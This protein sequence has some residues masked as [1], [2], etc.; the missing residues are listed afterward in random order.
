VRRT[1]PPSPPEL[2]PRKKGVLVVVVAVAAGQRARTLHRSTLRPTHLDFVVGFAN[3]GRILNP[4]AFRNKVAK[5]RLC[6]K[7][8]ALS[9]SFR[10]K[11]ETQIARAGSVATSRPKNE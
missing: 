6:S 4:K 1:P 7:E 5:K 9:C 2:R 11:T 3:P 10:K 8:D